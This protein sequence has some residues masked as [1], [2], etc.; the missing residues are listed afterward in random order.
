MTR[1]ILD[2]S[3]AA[4]FGGVAQSVE[5][6]DPSGRTLGYFT[7]ALDRSLYEGVECP[8]SNEELTRRER[9]EP[10]SSTQDVLAHLRRLE[11]G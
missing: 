4:R 8:V 7:P 11:Q 9:E 5:V 2:P 6:C 3:T 1:I 10:T